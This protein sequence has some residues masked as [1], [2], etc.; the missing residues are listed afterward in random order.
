MSN[1][2]PTSDLFVLTWDCLSWP[3][4]GFKRHPIFG[5][6]REG[7]LALRNIYRKRGM[8]GEPWFSIKLKYKVKKTKLLDIYRRNVFGYFTSGEVV[9]GHKKLTMQPLVGICGEYIC[10]HADVEI[11][12]LVILGNYLR[13]IRM[14]R[15]T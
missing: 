2:H 9:N 1:I 14:A 10:T 15:K 4:Q 6:K 13:D 7:M 8:E 12:I 5:S 11:V 3:E